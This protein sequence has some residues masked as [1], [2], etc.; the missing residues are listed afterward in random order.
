MS[1]YRLTSLFPDHAV[2]VA[3]TLDITTDDLEQL[4]QAA[5][6]TW[7]GIAY[8][9]FQ[10]YAPGESMDQSQ[11]IEVVMDADHI[12]SN[13]PRLPENVKKLLKSY[14]RSDEIRDALKTFVFRDKDYY[15]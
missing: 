8:D 12:L 13:N 4:L 11:V 9:V 10:A 1:K 2:K 15:S 5:H 7:D 14:K 3:K 6:S